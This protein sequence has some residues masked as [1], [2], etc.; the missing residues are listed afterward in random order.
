MTA[1]T[2]TA[3]KRDV[4]EFL[5]E[6]ILVS[7]GESKSPLTNERFKPLS[8][9]YRKEKQE[10]GAPGVPNLD[11]NGDMLSALE[12]RE[13]ANGIELGVFGDQAPKADGHNNFSGKSLIP[14]RR[15]LPG[16]GEYFRPGISEQVDNIIADAT[17]ETS[18]PALELFEEIETSSSFYDVLIE[19][20]GVETRAEAR[21]T[22]LRTPEWYNFLTR[23][24]LIR[25]L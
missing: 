25:Y 11:L 7:V 5:I 9:N 24:G 21:N 18:A 2:K 6:Q 13:T 19:Q 16:E 15:F 22:V 12:F 1:A 20:L 3:I 23:S 17:A 14:E 10:S 4:G 8:K